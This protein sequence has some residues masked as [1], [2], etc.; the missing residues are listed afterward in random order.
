MLQEAGITVIVF[1][2]DEDERIRACHLRR[3]GRILQ[4]IRRSVKM[5]RDRAHI[6][7]VGL[8]ALAF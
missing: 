5:K 2:D 3:E 8:D 4:V 6:N 7:Q 1:R